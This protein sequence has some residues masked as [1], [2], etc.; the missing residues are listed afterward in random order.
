MS[1]SWPVFLANAFI[2]VAGIL[3][4]GF[5]P[6]SVSKPSSLP[7]LVAL[8]VALVVMVLANWLA[9]RPLFRPLEHLAE[10]MDDADVLLS[11]EDLPVEGAGE[12]AT[13]ERAFNGMMARFEDERREAGARTIRAQEEQ[14]QRIA[15]GL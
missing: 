7:E 13:L 10:R 4:L 8:V 14:R 12:V 1:L 5:T 3:V 2:L 11:G 6:V 15:R 9:L